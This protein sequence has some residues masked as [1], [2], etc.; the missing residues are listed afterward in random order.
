[1]RPLTR[2]RRWVTQLEDAGETRTAIACRLKCNPSTITKL[3]DDDSRGVS[4][5]LAFSIE[6]ATKQWADGPIRA[7]EW[8]D[9]DEA[10][11]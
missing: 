10:A 11:A 8:D 1:M 5:R 6:R 4:L 9:S 3:M 7:I 2:F